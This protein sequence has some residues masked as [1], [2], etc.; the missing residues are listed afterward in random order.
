MNGTTAT[1]KRP[2]ETGGS[3]YPNDISARINPGPWLK[4]ATLAGKLRHCYKGVER[5]GKTER[6][7]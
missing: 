1:F 3:I 6:T 4:G 7:R 2:P 5:K